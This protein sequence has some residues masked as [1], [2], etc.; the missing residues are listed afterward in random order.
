MNKENTP[1]VEQAYSEHV[2]W[3]EQQEN[4][5]RAYRAKQLL[6]G[7][8]IDL[9]AFNAICRM[10][11]EGIVELIRASCGEHTLARISYAL[12]ERPRN[13]PDF[14]AAMKEVGGELPF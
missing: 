7:P 12:R 3:Q 4:K 10:K 9:D 8:V 5:W 6:Q 13:N 11:P 2:K 14:D 1:T